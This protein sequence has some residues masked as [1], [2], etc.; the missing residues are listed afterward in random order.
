MALL[1]KLQKHLDDRLI[2]STAVQHGKTLSL[3]G[4][5]KQRDGSSKRMRVSLD[6]PAEDDQLIHAE[7]RSSEFWAEYQRLGYLPDPMPWVVKVTP[8]PFTKTLTVN[9]AISQ[10]EADFF[11]GKQGN[12]QQRRSWARI[13]DVLQHLKPVGNA[14]VTTDLLVAVAE[15]CSDPQT[16]GRQDACKQFK[17]LAKLVGLKELDAL[18]QFEV[19]TSRS[20]AA[21]L[22]RRC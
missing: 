15:Q 9:S 1:S 21:V 7:S 6:L 22:M 12:A 2:R 14:P 11:R 3:R 17:R 13:A 16:R 20:N 18:I 8:L 5:F 19:I 4:T 10:L